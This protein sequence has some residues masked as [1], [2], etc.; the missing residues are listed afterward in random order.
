MADPARSPPTKPPPGWLWP[1]NNNQSDISITAWNAT[2]ARHVHE[3]KAADVGGRAGRG[4]AALGGPPPDPS[5]GHRTDR[6]RGEHR[7][8]GEGVEAAEVDED[9]VHD[10]ASR[11]R[12]GRIGR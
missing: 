7:D 1:A 11:D 9:H 12:Q 4:S 5:E 8:L 6:R 3:R 10:V 2:L